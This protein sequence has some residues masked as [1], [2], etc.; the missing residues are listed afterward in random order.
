MSRISVWLTLLFVLALTP[1]AAQA[2]MPKLLPDDIVRYSQKVLQLN[3]EPV[4]RLQSIS[5]FLVVLAASAG[6]ILGLWAWLRKDFP[7]LPRL[8]FGKALGVIVLW[9][10]MFVI[11]LTMISGARE[12][13]TP[14]AWK[15]N[16]ATYKLRDE[17]EAPSPRPMDLAP[18]SL[19]VAP[20]VDPHPAAPAPDSTQ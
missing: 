3:E 7:F 16:G 5:F 20:L 10:L 15:P 11:V 9:G 18:G 8:T 19:S 14:G 13:M 12:L 4:Q 1:E 17:T 2:G 6:G